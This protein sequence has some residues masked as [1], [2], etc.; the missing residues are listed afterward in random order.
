MIHFNAV[1]LFFITGR[2]IVFTGKCTL[3][4]KRGQLLEVFSKFPVRIN[5]IDYEV[6][7]VDSFAVHDD[8]NYFGSPLGLLV[9]HPRIKTKEDLYM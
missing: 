9:K 8:S 3:D 5:N 4:V 7:G 2:G 6:L 1:D